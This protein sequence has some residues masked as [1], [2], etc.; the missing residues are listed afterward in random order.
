MKKWKIY[1]NT[2]YPRWR[3]GKVDFCKE[4]D[5]EFCLGTVAIVRFRKEKQK[6]S[7]RGRKFEEVS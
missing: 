6:T 5:F 1:W 2:F 4:Y 3:I 7:E